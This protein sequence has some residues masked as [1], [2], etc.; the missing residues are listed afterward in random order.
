MTQITYGLSIQVPNGP[1]MAATGTRTVEAYDK[2]E[3]AVEPGG[4]TAPEVSIELQ[5][6]SAASVTL[7]LLKSSVYGPEINYKLSDGATDSPAVALDA[8]LLLLGRA[9]ALCG[10]APKLLKIK[11]TFPATDATRK[12][13]LE[14]LVGRDATP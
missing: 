3:L 2:I 10:V 12:A 8:P 14:I 11:N 9:V 6:A 7:V 4:G 1:Q 5:P 13:V